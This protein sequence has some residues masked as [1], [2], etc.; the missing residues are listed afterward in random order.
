MSEKIT[1]EAV[2]PIAAIV[3]NQLPADARIAVTK[4]NTKEHA[5]ERAAELFA[6]FALTVHRK[7]NCGT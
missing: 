5:V 2:L 6:E 4:D 7:M 3:F 1:L